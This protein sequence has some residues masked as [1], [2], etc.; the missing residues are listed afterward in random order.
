MFS[1][2]QL[3]FTFLFIIAFVA[4]MAWSY[5]KDIPLHRAYY[6]KVWIV[7]LGIVLVIAFFA[8]ITFWLH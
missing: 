1:T 2:G 6:P 8:A 4:V 3:V 5:R 7:A